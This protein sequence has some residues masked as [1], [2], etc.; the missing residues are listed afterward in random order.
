MREK[1]KGREKEGDRRE[2]NH[3]DRHRVV[4]GKTVEEEGEKAQDEG[5]GDSVEGSSTCS[6]E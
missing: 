4:R 6:R 1:D 2:N 5:K 3:T